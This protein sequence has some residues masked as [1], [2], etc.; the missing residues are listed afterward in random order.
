MP[1][2]YRP[3]QGC[4]TDNR[5]KAFSFMDVKLIATSFDQVWP[6]ALTF[7]EDFYAR[8]FEKD[9]DLAALFEP[10]RMPRQYRK[11]ISILDLVIGQAESGDPDEALNDIATYLRAMGGRH[12]TY[13]VTVEDFPKVGAALG[14]TFA[15]YLGDDWTEAHQASWD[16]LYDRVAGV[17]I[18]GMADAHA[19]VSR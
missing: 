7:A 11:M 13:G 2:W 10:A 18:A 4:G 5:R 15:H 16:E 12:A 1:G 3:A 19:P 17:L 14:D 6:H 9:P 8:L